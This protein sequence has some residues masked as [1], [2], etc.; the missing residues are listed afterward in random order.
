MNTSHTRHLGR[1]SIKTDI[2]S[3]LI[4]AAGIEAQ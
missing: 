2:D 4:K 1:R 3:R